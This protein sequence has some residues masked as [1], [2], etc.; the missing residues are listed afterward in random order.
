M[1]EMFTFMYNIFNWS[2]LPSFSECNCAVHSHIISVASVLKQS[3]SYIASC[4]AV[5]IQP[6]KRQ[7]TNHVHFPL[8]AW[9]RDITE[10][11]I[12]KD[13]LL[14]QRSLLGKNIII[15]QDEETD[16]EITVGSL[17][18]PSGEEWRE[19]N[20]RML[21]ILYLYSYHKSILVLLPTCKEHV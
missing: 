14:L 15:I 19:N 6:L 5:L 2:S 13:S 17:Q 16:S 11:I 10:L 21:P 20:F 12:F 9:Y 7:S 3:L 1:T 18:I 8:N 4:L